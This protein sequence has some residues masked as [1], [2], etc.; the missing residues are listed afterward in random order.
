MEM[1]KYQHLLTLAAF[2]QS[3]GN[4]SQFSVV[5]SGSVFSVRL[6]LIKV[7]LLQLK[8]ARYNVV[9]F[10]M[11]VELFFKTLLFEK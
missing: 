5:I 11:H 1:A 8:L 9:F 10:I 3:H 7:E 6:S 4:V 2:L